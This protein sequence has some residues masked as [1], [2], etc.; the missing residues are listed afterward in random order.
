MS[1]TD[2]FAVTL[3]VVEKRIEVS[4]KHP[5]RRDLVASNVHRA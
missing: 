5:L 1:R 4:K 2:L 3:F